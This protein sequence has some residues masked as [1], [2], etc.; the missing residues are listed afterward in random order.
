MAGRARTV[1]RGDGAVAEP[2]ADVTQPEE[3]AGDR[4]EVLST[5]EPRARRPVLARPT[6]VVPFSLE[7][8]AS[9]RPTYAWYF[10]P[11]IPE[12]GTGKTTGLPPD[13]FYTSSSWQGHQVENQTQKVQSDPVTGEEFHVRLVQPIDRFG[14]KVKGV[15][16]VAM[17][18]PNWTEEALRNW[19]DIIDAMIATR[20]AEVEIEEA[21]LNAVVEDIAS[22]ALTQALRNSAR[23]RQRRLEARLEELRQPV[24]EAELF[25]FFTAESVRSL[26]TLVSPERRMEALIDD[27]VEKQLVG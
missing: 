12:V 13:C 14:Q 21:L 26:Q 9:N 20:P 3:S 7:S 16:V 18:P 27:R 11:P 24:N 15:P 2:P 23:D 5:L 8:I 1:K 25:D 6:A 22:G 17:R 19:E 4:R 10:R